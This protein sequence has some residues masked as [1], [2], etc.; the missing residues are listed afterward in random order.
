[1]REEVIGVGVVLD[2]GA[3]LPAKATEGASGYDL[4]ALES[5]YVEIDGTV[6]I[7][8]G[9]HLSIPRGYEGQVRS[10]SGLALKHGVHVLNAPGTIDSDYRGEVGVIL[11]NSGDTGYTVRLGERIAQLV[12]A[13]VSTVEFGSLTGLDETARGKGGYGSTGV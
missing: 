4:C 13:P 6:L 12:I 9:V 11:H 3:V 1:M 8:T 7:K 10:R 2:D 5:V